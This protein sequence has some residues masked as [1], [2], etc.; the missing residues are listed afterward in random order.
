MR[1]FFVFNA[2]AG[3]TVV[4]RVTIRPDAGNVVTIYFDPRSPL[5]AQ[6]LAIHLKKRYGSVITHDKP[7]HA[8][9]HHEGDENNAQHIHLCCRSNV[10]QLLP[11][12]L[13][14]LREATIYL[15]R[16]PRNVAQDFP[17]QIVTADF[18]KQCTEAV[19]DYCRENFGANDR[20]HNEGPLLP[21][22]RHHIGM[23]AAASS[24]SAATNEQAQH[25]PPEGSLQA[26]SKAIRNARN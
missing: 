1:D 21:L 14:T 2:P 3:D 8:A 18:I 4:R 12:I 15:I 25:K 22:F 26:E 9:L 5:T 13:K 6:H 11:W 7:E 10:F 24:A 23:P 20:E 19:T 16:P 17:H